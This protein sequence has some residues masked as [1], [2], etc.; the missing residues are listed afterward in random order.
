MWLSAKT[1]I[2]YI[3]ENFQILQLQMNDYR[4]HFMFTTFVSSILNWILSIAELDHINVK[5]IFQDIE[6]F[7][8]EDFKY[9]SV[10]ITAFRLVDIGS[11]RVT[12]VLEQIQ[13]FNHNGHDILNNYT[14]VQ[15]CWYFVERN[16]IECFVCVLCVLHLTELCRWKKSKV[17]R[18]ER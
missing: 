5:L 4:Y 9:N 2:H 17:E 3:L 10:N 12:E 18:N 8:L 6:T 13:K 15:V 11:R 7:D 16:K 14:I 1:F